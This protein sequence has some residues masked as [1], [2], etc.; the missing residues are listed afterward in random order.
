MKERERISKKVNSLKRQ[1]NLRFR[2]E[3]LFVREVNDNTNVVIET[4]SLCQSLY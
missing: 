4:Y 3:V 2:I 1:E